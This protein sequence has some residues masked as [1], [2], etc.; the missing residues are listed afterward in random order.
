MGNSKD[1]GDGTFH[2][3]T[4]ESMLLRGEPAIVK[5]ALNKI[6]IDLNNFTI[7]ITGIFARPRPIGFDFYC[8]DTKSLL[9]LVRKNEAMRED[10]R[11]TL[12]G[13]FVSLMS[14]GHSIRQVGAGRALHVIIA[15]NGW[16]NAHI[17][18]IGFVDS[19]SYDAVRAL[20]HGYWDL[21]PHLLP[22]AFTT[23]G[24]TGVA[25]LMAAPMK[26]VD[27]ETRIIYGIAG[28]W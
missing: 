5:A 11:S 19:C 9:D 25:G 15:L 18:S 7:R 14:D 8:T 22:G 17:D 2:Y 13:K 10:D 24:K 23:F 21:A 3:Y 6:G 28:K 27:G 20:G 1:P 26:G 4:G 16:C 12:S